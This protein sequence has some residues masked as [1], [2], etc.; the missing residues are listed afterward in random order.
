MEK[1]WYKK[2]EI[3]EFNPNDWVFRRS[4]GYPGYDHKDNIDDLGRPDESKWIYQY[5]FDKRTQLKQDYEKDL[6]LLREF[7]MTS[8]PLGLCPDYML[9]E[10]LDNKYFTK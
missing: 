6:R 2:V 4:S 5:D 9:I 7:R 8:L 3:T 10:F 1:N